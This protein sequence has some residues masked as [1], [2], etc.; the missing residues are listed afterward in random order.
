M[1]AVICKPC[2][3][4]EIE[5]RE[6]PSFPQRPTIPFAE[7]NIKAF[8][9]N[10]ADLLQRAGHYPPPPGT[11]TEILGLE[12]SGVITRFSD[13]QERS[14]Q[15]KLGDRVMGICDG[16]AY[17]ESIIVPRDLLLSIPKELSFV[18]AA[19]I[20]EAHLTAFDALVNRAQVQPGERV[21][22]HAIGSG[23]GVA[24]AHIAHA[25]GAEVIGTTRS[26][27]KRDKALTEL[28]VSDVWLSEG[29][30][31]IPAHEYDGVD[32]VLDFVGAAYLKENLK[33]LRTCGR[34]IL[35][36]LLGGVRGELP[37]G[38][39]LAK[40]ASLI[41]TVLRS[42]S[43][44]EKIALSQSYAETLLPKLKSDQK[45][46]GQSPLIQKGIYL[47][48][49]NRVYQTENIDQAHQDLES[50]KIWSKVVGVW[51]SPK[52][53]SSDDEES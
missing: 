44:E 7:V 40:R 29:G 26:P 22:I 24:A 41:G 36:G 10:R 49:V 31:F 38:L 19:A 46:R 23:V 5:E 15:Y 11:S 2:G 25:L 18:Q 9:V 37:L 50:A 16:A 8:G 51:D 52:V 47:P 30:R 42:R 43:V 17:A 6:S 48:P 13:N 21:L 27:W 20:P 14:G 33:V 35:I 53:E 45:T 4:L 3:R 39:V 1:K 28:P 32:I 12:F 34:I